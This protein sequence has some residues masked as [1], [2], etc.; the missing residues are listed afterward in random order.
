[1]RGDVEVYM[2]IGNDMGIGIGWSVDGLEVGSWSISWKGGML[3]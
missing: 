1:M 3:I 2:G